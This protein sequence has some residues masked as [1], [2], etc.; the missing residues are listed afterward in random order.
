MP[1]EH[2]DFLFEHNDRR[3][4]LN[5]LLAKVDRK[6]IAGDYANDSL[7]SSGADGKELRFFLKVLVA[8]DRE[9]ISEDFFAASG[10]KTLAEREETVCSLVKSNPRFFGEAAKVTDG[11]GRTAKVYQ[12]WVMS[13]FAERGL[14]FETV[15]YGLKWKSWIALNMLYPKLLASILVGAVGI[16][17]ATELFAGLLAATE[18]NITAFPVTILSII[19]FY[20]F[21]LDY[22]R[23]KPRPHK[24]LVSRSLWPLCI[25]FAWASLIYWLAC[26]SGMLGELIKSMNPSEPP[27]SVSLWLAFTLGSF[28][29]GTFVQVFWD[30]DTVSKPI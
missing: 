18:K 22:G 7:M 19:Y 12:Q 30:K 9:G 15:H 10:L 8:P 26:V 27:R 2:D 4:K 24:E 5:D 21:G 11:G 29:M 17:S 23:L 1:G 13:F 3:S 6:V 28:L 16:L 20:F 14:M 25:G